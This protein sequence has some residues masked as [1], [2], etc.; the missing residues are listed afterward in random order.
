MLAQACQQGIGYDIQIFAHNFNLAKYLCV[1]HEQV[2][3]TVSPNLILLVGN[4][5]RNNLSDV[6]LGAK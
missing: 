1:A 5:F 2:K 3:I 4:T 6:L